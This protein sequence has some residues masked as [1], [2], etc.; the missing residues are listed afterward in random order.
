MADLNPL[1]IRFKDELKTEPKGKIPQKQSVISLHEKRFAM[2]NSIGISNNLGSS[3]ISNSK[4][5]LDNSVSGDTK[6]FGPLPRLQINENR[7]IGKKTS[8]I[9]Q[10]SNINNTSYLISNYSPNMNATSHKVCSVQQEVNGEDQKSVLSKSTFFHTD[11]I[12]KMSTLNKVP[13]MTSP[14]KLH[15]QR[16]PICPSFLDL[17]KRKFKEQISSKSD[18]FSSKK[19]DSSQTTCKMHVNNTKTPKKMKVDKGE[20]LENIQLL[21]IWFSPRFSIFS[22]VHRLLMAF[23]YILVNIASIVKNDWGTSTSRIRTVIFTIILGIYITLSSF[24]YIIKDKSKKSK[25]IKTCLL[26]FTISITLSFSSCL[27]Y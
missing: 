21:T 2:K 20:F 7:S 13:S 26:L 15:H 10:S 4:G 19:V 11:N 14:T 12:D 27:F 9:S 5:N 17:E 3:G 25:Y 23:I 8:I 24:V 6:H 22:L 16:T 1:K 18:T